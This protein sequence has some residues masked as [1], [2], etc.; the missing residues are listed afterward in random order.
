[1][2]AIKW[3]KPFGVVCVCLAVILVIACVQPTIKAYAL[4]QSIDGYLNE[5]KINYSSVE[6]N[7]DT[8]EV[9]LISSGKDRCTVDDV[10]AIHSVYTAVHSRD[11]DSAIMNVQINIYNSDAKQIYSCYQ[12]DV[13]AASEYSGFKDK[14]NAQ[15]SKSFADDPKSAL[16]NI[17][18]SHSFLVD[19]ISFAKADGIKGQCVSI[20]VN[21]VRMDLVSLSDLRILY[22]AIETYAI[23]SREITQCCLSMVDENGE[24]MFYFTG[25]FSFG[26]I[27]A[28][29]SPTMED[30]IIENEGPQH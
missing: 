26:N 13:A 29:V 1:M 24:C 20:M 14:I 15:D 11:V 5:R 8:L 27:T 23:P 25:D 19:D 2:N 18:T 22:E 6:I 17:I 10:N 3:G 30:S 9:N 28:W 12:A 16:S 21:P 7:K 4:E